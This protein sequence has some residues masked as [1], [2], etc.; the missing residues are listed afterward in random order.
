MRRFSSTDMSAK[1]RR[2]SGLMAMPEPTI[3]SMD[4]PKSSSP[5]HWME[6]EDALTRPVM[7][8]RVVDLP[9]PL[10]PISVT[11]LPSGTSREMPR[12]AWMPP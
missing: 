9:A 5:F 11:I 2:P 7:V 8:R 10:A 1:T 6:P 3:L 4:L 12:R